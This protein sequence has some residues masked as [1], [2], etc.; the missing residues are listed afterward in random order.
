MIKFIYPVISRLDM[1]GKK[2]VEF[3][4]A[5]I[6]V[7]ILILIGLI[8]VVVY[9]LGGFA[10]LTG[11]EG[12]GK[13]QA[14]ARAGLLGVDWDG[15]TSKEQKDIEKNNPKGAVELQLNAAQV[16]INSKEY[17]KAISLANKAK[18]LARDVALKLSAEELKNLN[19]KADKIIAEA[20]KGKKILDE[21][22]KLI[23]ELIEQQKA[24]ISES[25][26]KISG[27]ESYKK[28]FNELLLQEKIVITGNAEEE[29]LRDDESSKAI[30]K[31]ITE[32]FSSLLADLEKLA[33]LN[34]LEKFATD[35]PA[36]VEV[37]TEPSY[38]KLKSN[39]YLEL[40]K[41]YY[42]GKDTRFSTTYVKFNKDD[43]G[44]KVQT[45]YAENDY[46]EDK[47]NEG[48]VLE[49]ILYYAHTQRYHYLSLRDNSILE[50]LKQYYYAYAKHNK[51]SKFLKPIVNKIHDVYLKTTV[52]TDCP[53]YED[54]KSC[55]AGNIFPT[56][57]NI[58][59]KF[60]EINGS[61]D[62]LNKPDYATY[63]KAVCYYDWGGNNFFTGKKS[64]AS[65]AQIE[66]CKSYERSWMIIAGED[67]NKWNDECN[68]DPCGLGCKVDGNSCVKI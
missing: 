27:F 2:G 8:L 9:T 40:I 29:K 11:G 23:N 10:K 36:K 42:L 12:I 55:L 64:C 28:K 6:A 4:L 34:D 14:E 38:L 16:A 32:G 61:R 35:K 44:L 21:R 13:A 24:K 30:Y 63:R 46:D 58:F 60:D 49:G 37:K 59:G 1:K 47:Y 67:K 43:V 62:I 19:E 31:M 7:A 53:R 33:L 22:N 5:T 15:L 68:A 3:N 20:G 41:L 26:S 54:E 52:R 57:E 25:E 65:C 66:N 45:T 56:Q 17:D 51:L 48:E 39:V 50:E 18:E